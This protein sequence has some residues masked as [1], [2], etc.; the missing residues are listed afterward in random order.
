[1]ARRG[2][3]FGGESFREKLV[4]LLEQDPPS[5]SE[6]RR[7]GCS[8]ARAR[9][10]GVTEARRILAVAEDKSGIAD[11]R[12]LRKGDR[13]RG[14]VAGIIRRR[15]LV[16]NEWLTQ[17]LHMGVRNAVSRTIRLAREKSMSNRKIARI[18]RRLEHRI[19]GE[20]RR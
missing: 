13:S 2:W 10:Q 14:L 6:K 18:A 15:S 11:W 1:M 9:D 20:G 8:A 17:Q 19:D 5:V 7:E 16:A 3:Y 12:S 4:N